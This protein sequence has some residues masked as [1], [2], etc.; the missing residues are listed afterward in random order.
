MESC[1]WQSERASEHE[2]YDSSVVDAAGEQRVE[3][4]R[5]TNNLSLISTAIEVSQSRR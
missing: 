5:S 2:Y 4:K 3:K 1:E